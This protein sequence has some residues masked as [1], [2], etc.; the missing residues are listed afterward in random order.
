VRH[1]SVYTSQALARVVQ[2]IANPLF[3]GSIAAL[4]RRA[5]DNP[6]T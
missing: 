4:T 1:A 6:G 5:L 3:V 2:Q